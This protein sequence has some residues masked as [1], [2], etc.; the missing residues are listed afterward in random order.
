[1]PI[2]NPKVA[3]HPQKWFTARS[4]PQLLLS[5]GHHQAAPFGGRINAECAF[6]MF[7]G[8]SYLVISLVSKIKYDI[9]LLAI[10]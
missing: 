5:D 9:F 3:R 4:V 8:C 6:S 1:M 10:R 7:H 2:H